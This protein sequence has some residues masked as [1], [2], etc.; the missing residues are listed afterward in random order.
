MGTFS[1]WFLRQPPSWELESWVLSERKSAD[2]ISLL[3][4]RTLP[5]GFA[6]GVFKHRLS[7]VWNYMSDFSSGSPSLQE[8][9]FMERFEKRLAIHA[10]HP[11]NAL[12]ALVFTEPTFRQWDFYCKSQQSFVRALNRVSSEETSYPIEIRHT[13]DP[14]GSLHY[15]YLTPAA[16]E[17]KP[18]HRADA[19]KN[20]SALFAAA[21]GE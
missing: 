3:R 17:N 15:S 20:A 4:T 7:V 2:G 21:H 11:S 8:M 9:D 6:F 16:D 12:L 5:E 13:E 10:E 14:A 19:P 18:L 1:R